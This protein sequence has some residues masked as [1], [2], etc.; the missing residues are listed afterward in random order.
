M[1]NNKK[2]THS[3]TGIYV[4]NPVRARAHLERFCVMRD[5]ARNPPNSSPKERRK[6]YTKRHSE[7]CSEFHCHNKHPVFNTQN[8]DVLNGSPCI[9]FRSWMQTRYHSCTEP[10]FVNANT[11]VLK[12]IEGSFGNMYKRSVLRGN[13]S[14][15]GMLPVRNITE[16]LPAEKKVSGVLLALS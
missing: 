2:K 1:S 11:V 16:N 5:S 12:T 9:Y 14:T 4:K 15:R 6:N 8:K 7:P 10:E 3:E 13:R